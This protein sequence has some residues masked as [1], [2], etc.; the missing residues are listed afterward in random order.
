MQEASA[1]QPGLEALVA[2]AGSYFDKPFLE[3]P[4]SDWQETMRLNS[5]ATFLT[6]SQSDELQIG[7]VFQLT[8]VRVC[9]VVYLTQ[10]LERG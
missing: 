10:Q 6:S 1:R 3:L 2:N 4:R 9:L 7:E 8:P 5:E